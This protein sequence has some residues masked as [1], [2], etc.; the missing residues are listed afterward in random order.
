MPALLPFLLGQ[1]LQMPMNHLNPL[2]GLGKQ[3]NLSM[4]MAERDTPFRILERHGS[5]LLAPTM[6]AVGT[7]FCLSLITVTRGPPG[8]AGPPAQGADGKHSISSMSGH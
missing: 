1:S 8:T 5:V 2:T 4:E 3:A 6:P 7:L